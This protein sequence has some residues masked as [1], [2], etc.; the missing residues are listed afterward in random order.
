V[1]LS[2]HHP[3]TG[4]VKGAFKISVSSTY[5]KIEAEGVVSMLISGLK[6]K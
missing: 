4:V 6:N 2:S 1:S 5:D 3:N